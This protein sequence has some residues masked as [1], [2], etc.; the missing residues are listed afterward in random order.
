MTGQLS[1]KQLSGPVGIVD[2]VGNV[3]EQSVDY[4]MKAVVMNIAVY[5][6]PFK[7]KP[8]CY[9]PAAIAWHSTEVVWYLS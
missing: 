4:G 2:T 3:M 5:G 6:S 7:C 1:V 8:W 9:E